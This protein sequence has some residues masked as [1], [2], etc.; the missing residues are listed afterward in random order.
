MRYV[1]NKKRDL[2]LYVMDIF[3]PANGI[4]MDPFAVNM[5]TSIACMESKRGCISV[6]MDSESFRFADR[7]IRIFESPGVSITYLDTYAEHMLTT[8]PMWTPNT[9][10]NESNGENTQEDNLIYRDAKRINISNRLDVIEIP[11]V[12]N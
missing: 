9:S 3:V 12:K 2:F 7:R 11:T 6:E 5:S 10:F 1:A 8:D 4:V